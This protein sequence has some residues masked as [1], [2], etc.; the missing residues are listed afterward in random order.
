MQN[1]F[2]T[3]KDYI[4]LV[5]IVII[6]F[7]LLGANIFGGN[8]SLG[9]EL[10]FAATVTAIILAVLAIIFPLIDS[11]NNRHIQNAIMKISSDLDTSNKTLQRNSEEVDKSISTMNTSVSE[12]NRLS[13]SLNSSKIID[14][15]DDLKKEVSL[16]SS[17]TRDH[18][19]KIF[20]T[21]SSL[22]KDKAIEGSL[23]KSIGK[24]K[25]AIKEFISLFDIKGKTSVRLLYALSRASK[26]LDG[27]KYTRFIYSFIKNEDKDN[28]KDF[29]VGVYAC[30]IRF[31][32]I[33]GL[34]EF[35]NKF[36][37]SDV[38]KD[39]ISEEE[40]ETFAEVDS[41]ITSY[42]DKAK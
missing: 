22:G 23:L 6:V 1:K 27:D 30:M 10:T 35:D 17:A 8:T 32:R 21:N 34:I 33:F 42:L 4:Y 9:S 3:V 18:F 12:L 24:D 28:N 37:F 38:I 14:L 41:F 26:D 7:T 2:P 5:I 16:Q 15:I 19:T 13:E 20:E 39:I 11:A 40:P 29:N 36:V 25:T 31:L